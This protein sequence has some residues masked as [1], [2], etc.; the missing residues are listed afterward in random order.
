MFLILIQWQNYFFETL[1]LGDM[2]KVLGGQGDVFVG[3]SGSSNGNCTF[4]G[5]IS[6]SGAHSCN[7]GPANPDVTVP[8]PPIPVDTTPKDPIKK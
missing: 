7:E 1:D 2:E 5:Y 4:V 3:C 6:D 8:K